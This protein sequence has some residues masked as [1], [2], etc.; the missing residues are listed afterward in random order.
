MVKATI[1]EPVFFD[2][3][4]AE[5]LM[6]P[7]TDFVDFRLNGRHVGLMEVEEH[8]AAELPRSHGRPAG[9]LLRFDEDPLWRAWVG[10]AALM[11]IG[12][13]YIWTKPHRPPPG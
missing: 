2:L 11:A 7:R 10:A 8:F 6:A 5:G 1:C 9:V 13:A 3:L 12:A 4:R